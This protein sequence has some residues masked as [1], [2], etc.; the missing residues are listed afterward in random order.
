MVFFDVSVLSALASD[1]LS[2]SS[3]DAGAGDTASGDEPAPP[4]GILS[5]ECGGATPAISSDMPLIAVLL[6]MTATVA[7]SSPADAESDGG[8]F[9]LHVF[10]TTGPVNGVRSLCSAVSICPCTI[11]C[12]MQEYDPCLVPHEQSPNNDH[13]NTPDSVIESGPPGWNVSGSVSVVKRYAANQ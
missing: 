2:V 13:L 4:S 1:A 6:L 12:A 9:S 3:A 7:C 11:K 8:P 5:R 10:A